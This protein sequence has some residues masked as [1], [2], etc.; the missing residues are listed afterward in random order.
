MGSSIMASVGASVGA[1]GAVVAVGA[2]GAVVAVGAS[3]GAG[4]SVGSAAL[5]QARITAIKRAS[6]PANASFLD[7]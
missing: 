1:A 7:S 3:V 5:P 4:A 2:A 6:A